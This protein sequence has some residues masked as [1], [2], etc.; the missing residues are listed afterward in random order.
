MY[1]PCVVCQCRFRLQNLIQ[2]EL[3]C[4]GEC[5]EHFGDLE[6]ETVAIIFCNGWR[7]RKEWVG[8]KG[9]G[10]ELVNMGNNT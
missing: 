6:D 9:R 5:K 2:A 10:Y 7:G 3:G 1:I 8:D 4:Q